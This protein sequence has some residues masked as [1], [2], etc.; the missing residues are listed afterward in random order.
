MNTSMSLP[1]P[2]FPGMRAEMHAFRVPYG[3]RFSHWVVHLS[4]TLSVDVRSAG[5]VDSPSIQ[6][7]HEHY[8]HPDTLRALP[9]IAWEI[10]AKDLNTNNVVKLPERKK[11]LALASD[12]SPEAQRQRRI[13]NQKRNNANTLKTYKIR[14]K[15]SK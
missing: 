8:M 12:M 4:D 13:E 6:E 14:T 5:I 10:H 2:G 9:A 15:D 1:I 11:T 7:M 3:Y